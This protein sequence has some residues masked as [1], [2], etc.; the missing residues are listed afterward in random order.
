MRA[1]N[2]HERRASHVHKQ[3]AEVAKALC[4][5]LYERI[6]GDNVYFDAWKKQNEGCTSIE[7]ERRFIAKNWPRCIPTARATMALMLRG[8]YDD[9]MKA[10]ISEALILDATLMRGRANPRIVLN[11]GK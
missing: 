8:P 6:M 9:A 3:V 7:L 5:D 11:G 1:M 4:G 2:R 10:Q